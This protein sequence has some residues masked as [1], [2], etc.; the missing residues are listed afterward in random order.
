[1]KKF[2]LLI[3]FSLILSLLCLLASCNKPDK[4]KAPDNLSVEDATLTLSWNNIGGAR[5]Y[6]ISI[7]RDGEEEP[8]EYISSKSSYS[9]TQ[10]AEGSYTVKVRANGKEEESRDSDWSEAITFIREHENG[11]IFTLINGGTEYEVT[12][13]GTATGDVVIPDTYRNKPVTSIGKKAFFNK[14]DVTSVTFGKNIKAIGDFAF[15]NCSYLTALTLPE[16][17]VTIGESA[18]ASCRLLA[19]EVVIPD[20]VVVIPKNTFAYCGSL[21]SVVFGENLEIIGDNAFTDCRGLKSVSIPGSVKSIGK[22]AFSICE[23]VEALTFANGLTEISEYAFSGIKSLESVVLPDTLKIIGEGA[24]YTC[25]KL[26]DV[27]IG[28]KIESIDIGAFADTVIWNNTSAEN[29]VY[30]GKWFLGLKDNSVA[31]LNLRGDT[32]G[33]ADGALANNK[34]IVNLTLPNSIKIIGAAAFAGSDITNAVIGSGVEIIGMQ[35]FE[36]CKKLTNVILGSYVFGTDTYEFSSLKTISDYAFRDCTNL[37][38]I[39]IPETVSAIGTHVFRDSGIY[40]GSAGVVYA[41]NWVVDYNDKITDSVILKDGTVGIANYAFYKCEVLTSVRMPSTVKTVGR[42]AFYDCHA[43]EAVELPLML[44]RIEDYTFYKCNNLRLFVLPPMLKSIGRSAF[45]KCGTTQAAMDGDTDSDTLIIPAGVE[46]IGDFAFYCCGYQEKASIEQDAYVNYYGVDIIRIGSP[47]VTIGKSAFYGFNSLK[48]IELGGT[49]SIGEK[50]FYKCL[51]L[52][53]VDFGTSLVSIGER[54]FYKCESLESVSLPSSLTDIASYAFYKCEALTS[55][56][57]GGVQKIGT[58]A[59][60][61]NTN[62]KMLALPASLE[63]IGKQAF[64]NCKS[65]TSVVLGSNITTLDAHVFYGCTSLTLYAEASAAPEGWADHWNSS[66]RPV[67]YGCVAS[68]DK[69]YVIYLTTAEGAIKNITSV[70]ALSDPVREGYV[71]MGWGSNSSSTTANYDSSNL[72]NAEPG[73]K[74]YAIWAEAEN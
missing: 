56:S 49:V 72:T 48:R 52:K 39:E 11:M 57:L 34:S 45:Y 33:I 21:E 65:L 20:G 9:L 2:H 16:G 46:Y 1:M 22:Y 24:F 31:T 12:A 30:V 60:Y 8:K 37:L 41:G 73:R 50:A 17:L 15:G 70:S 38:A 66:Y 18:F 19:G 47:S 64:R 61:G 32:V 62:I 67:V 3:C 6:T 28:S 35:A 27:T 23:A 55:V 14:S 29:E 74:L 51:S 13:K 42:S 40:D 43:L 36:S 4:L 10:L 44:E 63:S 25:E 54:A 58:H 59:F 53:E 7:L 26:A 5:L 69:D 68:E 71:F